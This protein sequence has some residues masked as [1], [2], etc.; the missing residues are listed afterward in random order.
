MFRPVA[1]RLAC[2]RLVALFLLAALIVGL[3]AGPSAPLLFLAPWL[4]VLAPL[5]AG[6]YLGERSLLRMAR[7]VPGRPPRA[8]PAA[9]RPRLRPIVRV[10]PRGGCLLACSLAVRPPPALA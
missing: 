10:L 9:A 2:R 8:R 5:L 3:L 7:A 4:L 1:N 6:R